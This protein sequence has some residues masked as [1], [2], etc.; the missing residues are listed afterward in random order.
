[1][2][3]IAPSANVL[4]LLVVATSSG[5][6]DADLIPVR[7]R[8]EAREMTG[9]VSITGEGGDVRA[10]V[11]GVMDAAGDLLDD[12]F[13]TVELRLRVNGARR[14]MVLGVPVSLGDGAAEESLGLQAGSRV[15]VANVRLRGPTRKVLAEAG[16]LT[17]AP[18]AGPPPPPD[19]CPD[20]L[21]SC[22]SDLETCTENL[23]ACESDC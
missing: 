10:S 2:R 19:K 11:S 15:V 1:M 12:R 9:H 21:D 23:D 17:V 22:T 16:A 4:L 18:I 13:V 5:A 14:R 8:P 20:A 6:Y 3:L 7:N